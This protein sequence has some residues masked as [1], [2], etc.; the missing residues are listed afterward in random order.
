MV[1]TTVMIEIECF[2]WQLMFIEFDIEFDGAVI[3]KSPSKTIIIVAIELPIR[4]RILVI[5][6]PMKLW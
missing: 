2:D 1:K 5:F 3:F 4:K 6:Y